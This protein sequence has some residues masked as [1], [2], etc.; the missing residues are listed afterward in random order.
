MSV[1][2]ASTSGSTIQFIAGASNNTMR[3]T[4][5]KGASTSTAKGVIHFSTAGTSGNS[6]NLLENCR[7][8]SGATR[9]ANGI[10][11]SGTGATPN[12]NNTINNCSIYDYSGTGIY[13][14]AGMTNTT[15]TRDTMYQTSGSS[16]TTVQGVYL[17]NVN[18][19][20]I[21]N[22]LIY[23]LT[24][25]GTAPTIRGI[26]YFGASSV[27][28]TQ[29]VQNNF[30]SLEASSTKT[31]ATVRGI[32][33][34][35]YAG[36]VF[37][38]YYNS[39]YIGGTGVV[40]GTTAAIAKRDECDMEM[41]NNIAFNARTGGTGK[42][43][44]VYVSDIAG[45]VS[46][47]NNDYYANGTNGYLGY[48]NVV[49]HATLSTWQTASS[50]DANSVS[51]DPLYI[52]GTNLHINN[53]AGMFSPT[54]NVGTSIAG[55]L[56]DIDDE[57]R[58]ALPDIGAD[59][60]TLPPP[61]GFTLVSPTGASQPV[62][63]TLVWNPS[64]HATRYDVYVEIND[65]PM[66]LVANNVTDTQYTF[67]G[68]PS[69]TYYWNVYAETPDADQGSRTISSNGP[70]SFTTIDAP[71]SPS[72]LTLTTGVSARSAELLSRIT[73]LKQSLSS[74]KISKDEA[75][76]IEKQI[77]AL[78]SEYLASAFV[79]ATWTD[80]ASNEDNFYIYRKAGSA[81]SIGAPYTDRIAVL[82]P[83]A[84]SGG[85][86]NFNDTPL[87]LNT[88]YY[89]RVTAAT[90]AEVESGFAGADTTTLAETPG[91]PVFADVQFNNMRIIV[92]PSTNPADVEFAIK[93][94]SSGLYI[95]ATGQIVSASPVWQTAAGWGG[96]LGLK[97]V[98]L[99]RG[100]MYAFNVKARNA[101]GVETGFGTTGRQQ[102]TFDQA[103]FYN[104]SSK[105]RRSIADNSY[106]YD[107]IALGTI[108]IQSIKAG[109]DSL[110]HTYDGDIDMFLFAPNGDSLELSTDNGGTGENFMGTIFDDAAA[111]S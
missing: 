107:T 50:Q 87:N 23:G 63:V 31:D 93:D 80:N 30:I 32:D 91:A 74:D 28:I 109:I 81:P 70:L 104:Y 77:E 24:S 52:S 64:A 95:N 34:F 82:G 36:N 22:N 67:S 58:T 68:N 69:T 21:Q 79:Q 48:W 9:T 96:G 106:M 72:N 86:V 20:L 83:S 89:Y 92:D 43:Y 35:P 4:V 1:E 38:V 73:S 39:I 6:N 98:N 44:A 108:Q 100:T 55:I 60:F 111:T 103:V 17:G 37:K 71:N 76:E 33:A 59:E 25:T 94:S 26:Y 2:N 56:S 101:A 61:D 16:G 27:T 19:T 88:H 29:T 97:L 12:T 62:V 105:N 53:S 45:A 14:S 65:P 54:A 42:H 75:N 18:G 11:G 84:G 3:N 99:E 66:V 5:L 8:T 13:L 85:T 15:I 7:I 46:F 41:K 102:T 49:D 47:N 57:S 51:G 78:T 10:Y 90:I 40:S 110:Y